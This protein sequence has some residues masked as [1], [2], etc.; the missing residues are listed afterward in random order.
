MV[1]TGFSARRPEMVSA[2]AGT[3][4]RVRQSS[5]VAVKNPICP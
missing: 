2:P 5:G 1:Q 3:V 4:E